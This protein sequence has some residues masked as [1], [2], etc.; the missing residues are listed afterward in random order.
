MPSHILLVLDLIERIIFIIRYRWITALVVS[1][2]RYAFL[3]YFL[4]ITAILY[5][6]IE[7]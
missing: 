4:V 1:K 2:A 7:Y 3:K 6:F 5:L